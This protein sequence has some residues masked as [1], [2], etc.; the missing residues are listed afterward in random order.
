MRNVI[1][2]LGCLLLA[3]ALNGCGHGWKHAQVPEAKWD[4]DYADCVHQA[5]SAAK[6]PRVTRDPAQDWGTYGEVRYLTDK[7]MEE[8][9][10]FQAGD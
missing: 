6:N 9:G 2:T 10:Y 4:A 7:C 8:K 1:L 3:V 5:E